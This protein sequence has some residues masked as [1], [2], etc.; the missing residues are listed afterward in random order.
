MS[1]DGTRSADDFEMIRLKSNQQCLC[2]KGH[3][4]NDQL[5]YRT[6]RVY[7]RNYI[8]MECR[9][10]WANNPGAAMY[11]LPRHRHTGRVRFRPEV[12]TNAPL[13]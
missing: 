2:C 13:T 9:R 4:V 11:Q 6:K 10:D 1:L 8:C 3:M 7:Q 12:L 5:A